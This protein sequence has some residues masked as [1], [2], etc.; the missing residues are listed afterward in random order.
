MEGVVEVRDPE[1][2]CWHTARITDVSKDKVQVAFEVKGKS[3]TKAWV[4]WDCVR[5]APQRA[6]F[7][8]K[9]VRHH[10]DRAAWQSGRHAACGGS[11]PPPSRARAAAQALWVPEAVAPRPPRVFGRPAARDLPAPL[12]PFGADARASVLRRA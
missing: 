3:A 8:L 2:R 11:L 7:E 4:D 12:T 10:P 9:E 1:Q 6:P 5:E